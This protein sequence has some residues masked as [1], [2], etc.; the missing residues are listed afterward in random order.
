MNNFRVKPHIPEGEDGF[1]LLALDSSVSITILLLSSL[2]ELSLATLI[3]ATAS[4]PS[5]MREVL[6]SYSDLFHLLSCHDLSFSNL[7]P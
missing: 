1:T 4:M 2:P 7:H 5:P 6:Y 3:T